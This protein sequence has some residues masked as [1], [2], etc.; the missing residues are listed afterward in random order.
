MIERSKKTDEARKRNNQLLAIAKKI[1]DIH[2][3]T[4]EVD[5]VV[6]NAPPSPFFFP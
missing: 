1:V 2:Q 4:L 5:S 6:G 3:G